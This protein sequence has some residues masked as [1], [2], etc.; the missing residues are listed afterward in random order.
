MKILVGY[1]GSK[2]A[3]DAVKLA[4][5]HGHAAMQRVASGRAPIHRSRVRGVCQ[6]AR[7]RDRGRVHPGRQHG[8]D[9][10]KHGLLRLQQRRVW[11]VAARDNHG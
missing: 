9:F 2:V 5:Q 6:H 7:R 3:E 1:D 4:Q 11:H 8:D 10:G